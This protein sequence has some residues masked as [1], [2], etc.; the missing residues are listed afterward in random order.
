[1][2]LAAGAVGM[3]PTV[4]AANDT[5]RFNGKWKT[6]FLYN[7]QT[8]TMVSIHEGSGFENYVLVP[9]GAVAAGSGTFSAV[10]GKWTASA[11]KP[12]NSG[13]YH[14]A[15]NNTIMCTNALGQAVVWQRDDAPLPP[16]VA[17][18]PGDHELMEKYRKAADAG[19]ADAMNSIGLMY[20]NGQ[21]AP[22]DIQQAIVWY[23]KAA[24]GGNSNAE[25]QLGFFYGTGR[26]VPQDYRQAMA[27]YRKSADKGNVVAMRNIGILYWDGTGVPMDHGL[28]V[29]WCRKAA[30][31][32]DQR[33][34]E[35][36]RENGISASYPGTAPTTRR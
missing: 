26:G 11:D 36:L 35:W 9:N 21:G 34:Q 17:P 32:G 18:P 20:E 33:S 19:D 15:N 13:T 29:Y 4:R 6:S 7:G 22:E 24:A 12:N 10:D 14:F 31:G 23:R 3:V 30:E 2:A 5:A 8:V 27:W 1:M 25:L 16:V 28:A